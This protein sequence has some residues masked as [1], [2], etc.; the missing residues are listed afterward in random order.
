[1][2]R[3]SSF[4]NE[5]WLIARLA[6]GRSGRLY[7]WRSPGELR[8]FDSSLAHGSSLTS[9]DYKDRCEVAEPPGAIV[10]GSALLTTGHL[11][12]SLVEFAADT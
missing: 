11:R 8:A 5:D 12:W 3:C 2:R 4:E 1:M 7:V 6:F 10:V 9:L